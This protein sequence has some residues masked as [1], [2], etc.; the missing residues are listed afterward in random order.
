MLPLQAFYK[1]VCQS[2]IAWIEFNLVTFLVYNFSPWKTCMQ[3]NSLCLQGHIVPICFNVLSPK[4]TFRKKPALY[5]RLVQH[6]MQFFGKSCVLYLWRNVHIT[7][8]SLELHF[9]KSSVS[10]CIYP[11]GKSCVLYL[12]R[13]AHITKRSSELHFG[14][15]PVRVWIYPLDTQ[16]NYQ[17]TLSHHSSFLSS[18]CSALSITNFQIQTQKNL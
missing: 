16:G 8:R 13:N 6:K 5:V 18:L 1:F 11:L 2:F 15:S 14:K 7:E 9:G 12:W 17:I 10:V 3:T 4:S